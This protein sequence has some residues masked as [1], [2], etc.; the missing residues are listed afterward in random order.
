MEK[1]ILEWDINLSLLQSKPIVYLKTKSSIYSFIFLQTR[2]HHTSD[3]FWTPFTTRGYKDKMLKTIMK[4]NAAKDQAIEYWMV[5]IM[6]GEN[7]I[8]WERIRG[9][10]GVSFGHSFIKENHPEEELYKVRSERWLKASQVSIVSNGITEER[11]KIGQ[12]IS[13][14]KNLA[15]SLKEHH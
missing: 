8:L 13:G 14:R 15:L 10:V 11:F 5:R 3:T 12:N 9:V 7:R 2:F 1:R 4:S 6:K